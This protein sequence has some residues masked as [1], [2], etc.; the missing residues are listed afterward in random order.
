MEYEKAPEIRFLANA[1]IKALPE[2]SYIHDA[3]IRIGYLKC[4]DVQ[5]D[6]GKLIFGKCVKV[7]DMYLPL[8]P[9]DFL[10]II[11][12]PN[13]VG[14]T[15]NQMKVLI[16]HELKHVGVDYDSDELKYIVNPHDYEDFRSIIERVGLDWSQEGADIAD[17][18]AV[19]SDD[20]QAGKAERNSQT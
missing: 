16:W 14:F 20:R 1:V 10:I 8:V 17:I 2:L 3:G 4:L 7:P 19:I 11:N 18:T 12:E 6:S 9:Y 13:T 15:P 5:K